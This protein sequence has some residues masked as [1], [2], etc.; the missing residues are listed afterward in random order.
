MAPVVEREAVGFR[1]DANV[2]G[3]DFKRHADT[4]LEANRKLLQRLATDTETDEAA[5]AARKA[6]VAPF[7]GRIDPLKKARE[8]VL[9]EPM[10]KRGTE[11][12]VATTVAATAPV[13]TFSHFEAAR[14]L[15]ARGVRMDKAVHA[16][17]Q[18][19]HPEGVPET[20]IDALAQ[21]LKTR[22]TLQVVAGGAK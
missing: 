22:G 13:R 17:I 2:I 16:L 1:T 10:P 14:E 12:P 7:G 11:L 18:Q 5:V 20:E 4:Q 9:P 21:R 3:E 8:T 15:L 19:Q 6:R